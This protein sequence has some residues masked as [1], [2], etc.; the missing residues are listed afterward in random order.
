[1]AIFSLFS[2][3]KPRLV[4]TGPGGKL[5]TIVLD[6]PMLTIGRGT[7]ADIHVDDPYLAPTHAR[8]ERQKDGVFVV[9]RMGLNPILLA[10]QPVLQTA[11]LRPGDILQFGTAVE[12]EYVTK[13]PA[14]A[15][16]APLRSAA[17]P[18][19]GRKDGTD[20]GPEPT[21]PLL[22]RPAFLAAVGV[23]YLGMM[24][25]VA[26]MLL[27]SGDAGAEAPSAALIRAEADGILDC[28]TSARRLRQHSEASFRGAVGGRSSGDPEASY[29]ALALTDEPAD[30]AG[31]AA[32]VAPIADAYRK[33]A[34]AGLAAEINGNLLTAGRYY[35]QAYETVPD[36]N[37]SATQFVLERKAF[38][39]AALAEAEE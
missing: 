24:A 31:L 18:V 9:R 17:A 12:F 29:G 20:P 37:C 35:R 25:A 8:I 27:Q 5:R 6:R 7:D 1:M 28:L 19:A 15:E 30:D 38:V 4:Q 13:G 10:G 3:S 11:T 14:P 16:A 21:K 36:I 39:A 23:V 34:L 26:M 33:A 22:K 32:A 2:A